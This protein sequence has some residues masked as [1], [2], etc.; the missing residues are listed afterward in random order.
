[1]NTGIDKQGRPTIALPKSRAGDY[2][3]LRAEMDLIVAVSSCADDL[4]D[5]NGGEL[6]RI[7]VEISNG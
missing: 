7:G 4:S 3:D 2:V 1:M 5:C 6:T